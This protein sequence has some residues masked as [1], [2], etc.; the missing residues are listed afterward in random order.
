M[1][2]DAVDGMSDRPGA[3]AYPLAVSDEDGSH[4]GELLGFRSILIITMTV[5]TARDSDRLLDA[6]E[7]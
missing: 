4:S 5:R 1:D 3:P 6:L 2:P 7:V